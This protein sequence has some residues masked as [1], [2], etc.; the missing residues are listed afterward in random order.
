MADITNVEATLNAGETF[1]FSAG[2]AS[3]TF[4]FGVPD[5]KLIVLVKNEDTSGTD[6]AAEP[7]TV[8]FEAGDF[9]Q[10]GYGD[11]AVAVTDTNPLAVV[12]LESGV[13][14]DADGEVTVTVTD[15]DGSEFTGTEANVK[16]AVI[17][18][19]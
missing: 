16:I 10:S 12:E 6:S 14:K 3:Q 1:S 18:L 19:E 17:E 15:A 2:A 4:E 8:T 13:V 9:I 5:E 11:I 7:A